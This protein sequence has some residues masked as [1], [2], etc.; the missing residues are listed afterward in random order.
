MPLHAVVQWLRASSG[1]GGAANAP[2]PAGLITLAAGPESAAAA[3]ASL[4]P[5]CGNKCSAAREALEK[6]EPARTAE[7]GLSSR[8]LPRGLEIDQESEGLISF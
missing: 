8:S 4:W 7:G 3:P 2:V 6:G 5:R 1:S